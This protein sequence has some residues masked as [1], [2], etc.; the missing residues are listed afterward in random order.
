M[1]K[2]KPI[3]FEFI[4]ILYLS[5]KVSFNLFSSVF[6]FGPIWSPEMWKDRPD[7]SVEN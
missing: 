7:F 4:V 2:I 5:Y 3:G 1:V 6:I